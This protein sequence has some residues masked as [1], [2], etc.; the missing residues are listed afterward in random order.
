MILVIYV[1]ETY[2]MRM[3]IYIYVLMIYVYMWNIWTMFCHCW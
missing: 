1:N 3:Q 2:M